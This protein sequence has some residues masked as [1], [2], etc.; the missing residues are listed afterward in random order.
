MES[1]FH[2]RCHK[3]LDHQQV[4]VAVGIVVYLAK[5]ICTVEFIKLEVLK[6]LMFVINGDQDTLK[7]N[8]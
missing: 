8:V 5:G 2:I 6:I 7:D 4:E 1:L 3:I